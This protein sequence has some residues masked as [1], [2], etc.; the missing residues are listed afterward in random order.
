MTKERLTICLEKDLIKMIDYLI[1]KKYDNLANR[2]SL[3]EYYLRKPKSIV[4]DYQKI[5]RE[6]SG[7]ILT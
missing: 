7:G 3:I 6:H 4:E 2:S 1:E 5:V